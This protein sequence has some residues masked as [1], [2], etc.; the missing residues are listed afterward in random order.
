MSGL[1]FTHWGGLAAI[2]FGV[3]FCTV[4]YANAQITPDTTLP[5]NTSVT[6]EGNTFNITGGTQAGGNLFHSFGEFS[7][8]T[9]GI[10]S[11]N[12]PLDIQNIISRVTGGSVSNIDGLIRANGTANLF[13]INPSGIVFGKNASLDIRGAFT[14]TTANEIKLGE[15][16]L[17]SATEPAKSNL[18]TIQPNALFVNALK[19]QQAQINNQANLTV[20]EGKN[21]TLFGAN[22]SNTGILTAQNGTINLT[23]AENLIVR[24]NLEANTLLLDTKNLNIAESTPDNSQVTIYKSTLEG[25]SGN[26]NIILQAT[27][28]ITIKTLSGN[29]LN[30]ANGSGKVTFN[31]DVDGDGIGNFQMQTSDAIKTNGR[32][33]GIFGVSLTLGNID[34]S[35]IL[36][37]GDINLTA[38]EGNISTGNLQSYSRSYDGTL[39]RSFWEIIVNV[40][41]GNISTGNFESYLSSYDGIIGNGGEITLNA[42]GNISTG[43]LESYSLSTLGTAGN[44]GEITLTAQGNIST[45]DIRSSSFSPDGIA[46][47]GGDITLTAQGNISTQSLDSSSFSPDGIAGNGGDITLTAQGNISTQSLDS[48][49]SSFSIS[50]LNPD[51]NGGDITL[52]AQGNISTQSLNSSSLV[53]PVGTA[54]NGG[55]ITLT[56]Q[57]NISTGGLA[58]YIVSTLGTA[59]NGGEITLTAQGNISTGDILSYSSLFSYLNTG[60]NGGDIT[61]AAQGNISTQDLDSSSFSYLSTAGNG[62]DITLTAQGD[63]KGIRDEY[64]N[65]FPVFSSFSVSKTRVSG[66]GGNVTLV[67]KNQITDLKILTLSSDSKSGDVQIKGFGDLSL[68]NTDIITSKQ[69]TIRNQNLAGD[70]I[71]DVEGVSQSGNVTVISTGNLTFNNSRIESDTRGSDPAGNITITSPGTVTFNNNNISKITSNTSSQGK[72]GNIEINANNLVL[73]DAS[74]ISAST[75]A[76]GKAGD[77]TLNTPTLTVANG[78]KIFATTTGIG[79]G[80]TITINAP[81]KVNLGIGVQDFSPILSVETSGAGKAGDIIVNT[82]SL[83][84]SDTARITA[85]ATKTA[86]N[87]QG[88]GSITLNASK[89]DLAGIVGVFAETQGEAPAGTLKLNPY[90]NQPDLD[91]TLFPNSTISASTSAS[92]KGGDLILAAPETINVAG[93][94]KLTVESTGT[95]DAGN[96]QI[97]TQ[98]LNINDGVKISASNNN[99]GKGGNI[100]VNANNLIANNGA[101]LLTATSGNAPA[102]NINLEIRDQISLSGTDTGLFANTEKGSIGYG[103]NIK[104]I[105]N[106]FSL[107]NGGRVSTSSEGQGKAGDINISSG[108]TTLDNQGFIVAASNS[109]D[110]GNINLTVDD[111]LLLRGGSEISTTAGTDQ[112]GGNGGNISINAPNGFIVAVPGENSDITANAFTGIGGRVD[113]KANGIYGIQFRESPTPLSDITASSEFGTQGTV[114]LNT[115]GIDP[116][117][118]LVEL[119]T[120]AVDT[121]IGQGC[122]SPGYA[123][124]SFIITGRGGLPPN[125]REAFSSNIVRPE[126]ATLGPSND[127]NSQQTIKENPPIPTPAAPIVEATGWGTNTKGEIVLTAN[128]STG[129]PHKSWQ[130]SSVTCSS[131]KSADN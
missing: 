60:G 59:G 49:S 54:G 104:L 2:A 106:D 46:G 55:D 27:N 70:F 110:G 120:V 14:A 92:G 48:S 8:N 61:L 29:S 103:G 65:K 1:G 58:S 125:P 112:K 117:S 34:T 16:G 39:G 32:D 11:F 52:T 30:L 9:G 126:W 91:I 87:T 97:L 18:L 50:N 35:L 57:G 93:Q 74:E 20:G 128:A 28:D 129:T 109:G 98:N 3:S 4:D 68:T 127:I 33:I 23:G 72:A 7:V 108:S 81:S 64:T 13:L 73:T 67:A 116:N 21:I 118:G 113:I 37:G 12:N 101:Q 119:P 41:E 47:N 38:T 96:I 107:T 85:T 76:D 75:T 86:T 6:R 111:L 5:N 114:E 82:P 40:L 71:L 105:T 78:G 22:V 124:N 26:T 122:Y 45:Q 66:Q 42:Q 24:G 17:F 69:I 121:Q 89:I 62:G 83:T 56:A 10:A 31:A 84:V 51:A 43:N 99:T 88:G 90:Q 123:Q 100:Q 94:G 130:Q 15:K 102:G 79:D 131:A 19:N 36:G 80:G 63:I 115:P 25:L 95:G 53:S 44:G 77:I